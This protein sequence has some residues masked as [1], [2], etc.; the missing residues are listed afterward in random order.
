MWFPL[1]C[2]CQVLSLASSAIFY[3]FWW[4]KGRELYGRR[5]FVYN[6]EKYHDILELT[7]LKNC[8]TLYALFWYLIEYLLWYYLNII[9]RIRG[10]SGWWKNYLLNIYIVCWVQRKFFKSKNN[11]RNIFDFLIRSKRRRHLPKIWTFKK[12]GNFFWTDQ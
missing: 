6:L 1:C 11:F 9:W 5:V 3:S 10:T 12:F 8:R 4:C 2:C 7:E